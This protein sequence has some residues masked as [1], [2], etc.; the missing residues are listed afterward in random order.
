MGEVLVGKGHP[1]PGPLESFEVLHQG[2]Q[3]LMVHQEALFGA[4][5]LGKIVTH[6]PGEGVGFHPLAVLPVA[7]A[8][9]D[10]A[11]VDLRI[12][13]GG[14]GLAMVA[15][16]A[17]DDVQLVDLIEMVLLGPGAEDVGDAGIKAGAEQSHQVL[18]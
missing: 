7:A 18:G 12:E 11:D 16:I 3:F 1:E 17:V 2:L 4:D 15:G 8:L 9:R 5:A 13:V 6:R 14:K 10:L